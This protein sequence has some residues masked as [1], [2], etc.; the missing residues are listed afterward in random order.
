MS[1]VR[2]W[3][4][5]PVLVPPSAEELPVGAA[6]VPKTVPRE[7]IEY[8]LSAVRLAPRVALAVPIEVAVGVVT[9]GAADVEVT[10]RLSKLILGLLPVDPPL[11]L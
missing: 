4:K 1:P 2:L 11:P 8:P 7:V 6:E 5:V 10:P 9:V 3:L